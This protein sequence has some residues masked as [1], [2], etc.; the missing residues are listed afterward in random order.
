M[1]DIIENFTDE[2][3]SVITMKEAHVRLLPEDYENLPYV[4]RNDYISPNSKISVGDII[5]IFT[6]GVTGVSAFEVGEILYHLYK[7]CKMPEPSEL[8]RAYEH[9][10]HLAKY[11][12]DSNTGRLIK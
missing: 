6:D 9:M 11:L 5:A 2:D 1:A 3:S 4:W 12:Y 10:Y 8:T 7:W